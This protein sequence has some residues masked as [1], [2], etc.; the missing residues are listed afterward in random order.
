MPSKSDLPAACYLI[1]LRLLILYFFL[2]K[3]QIPLE[4]NTGLRNLSH[5]LL[6][7]NVIQILF[8]GKQYIDIHTSWE[9]EMKE[10]V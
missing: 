10:V 2:V 6:S 4:G 5:L 9:L 8:D 3:M 1:F 7:V